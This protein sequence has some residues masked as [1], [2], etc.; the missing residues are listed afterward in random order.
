LVDAS[1]YIPGIMMLS[2]LSDYLINSEKW[3]SL[4]TDLPDLS[5]LMSKLFDDDNLLISFPRVIGKLD[6]R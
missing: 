1:K 4:F 2:V 3:K 5:L 6:V